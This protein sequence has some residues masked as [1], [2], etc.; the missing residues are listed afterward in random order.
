[1]ARMDAKLVGTTEEE[2][3][4]ALD[5]QKEVWDLLKKGCEMNKF[6]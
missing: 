4:K 2:L 6:C 1:M 5:C 3:K